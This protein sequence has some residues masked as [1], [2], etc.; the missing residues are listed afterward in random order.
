M[1]GQLRTERNLL[2]GN[3]GLLDDLIERQRLVFTSLVRLGE[4]IERIE[5]GVA[6]L[7]ERLA[8]MT[9]GP[10]QPAANMPGSM[11]PPA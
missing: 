8:A 9:A 6:V 11:P 7:E 2:L 4:A 3:R 10:A 5:A 1:W